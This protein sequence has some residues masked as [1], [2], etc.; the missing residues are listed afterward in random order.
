VRE[1]VIDML[2]ELARGVPPPRLTAGGP[3]CNV[4]TFGLVPGGG[5][6][7]VLVTSAGVM[8]IEVADGQSIQALS[9]DGISYPSR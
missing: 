9:L 8:M 5:V 3:A 6:V 4:W 7:P 2:E 1:V